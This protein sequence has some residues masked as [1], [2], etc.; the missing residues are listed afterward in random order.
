MKHV[1]MTS[2]S[3][4]WRLDL[5]VTLLAGALPLAWDASNG[6]LAAARAFGDAS[7]F[8][9]RDSWWASRLIHDGGRML[10]WAVLAG[11]VLAALRPARPGQHS[12]QH[13]HHPSRS[14]RWCWIGV[15]LLCVVAVPALKRGSLTSCPW[16]LAEFG[17]LAR[18][19]SHWAWARADGGP[20][21]C[22][23]SGHAVAAFAFFGQY[24][25]WRDHAPGRA[26]AW[27]A[28]VLLVGSVY[29]GA[30][31]AR[32]AHYPSHTLWSAWLCWLI[33]VLA[34]QAMALHAARRAT[35]AHNASAGDQ[36]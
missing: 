22:F 35:Q 4:R 34:A 23:P 5:V 27:L 2:A 12:H 26:R 20:G 3:A 21:H 32:G 31:L 10:S 25:L 36:P 13:S 1:A 16:D 15:M 33:C 18:H 19:V 28:A 30:Q 6:D 14:Q 7:G 17:G 24:F 9:Q 11:L 8:A 29:G